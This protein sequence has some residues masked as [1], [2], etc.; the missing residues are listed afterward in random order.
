MN[1]ISVISLNILLGIADKKAGGLKS[2]HSPESSGRLRRASSTARTRSSIGRYCLAAD[3]LRLRHWLHRCTYRNVNENAKLASTRSLMI[4]VT[5][6]AVASLAGDRRQQPRAGYASTY[7]LL[8]F[9]LLPV[10][11]QAIGTVSF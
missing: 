9:P 11:V 4:G 2:Q 6:V 7:L 1:V 3:F 5:P 8:R 10:G